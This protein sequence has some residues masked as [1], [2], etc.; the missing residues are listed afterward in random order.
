MSN[1]DLRKLKR[2]YFGHLMWRA[3]S[4]EKTLMLG[5]I[6]GRRRRGRQRMRWW[7]GITDSTDSSLSKLREMVMDREAC[8]C[9]VHEVEKSRTQLQQ[10]NN[11]SKNNWM[12]KGTAA[13][14]SVLELTKPKENLQSSFSFS[15]TVSMCSCDQPSDEL[16]CHSL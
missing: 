8:C 4:S 9:A 7:D 13:T 2:R 3:D 12:F 10:L 15:E 11:D 16:S 6:E 5:K 1:F 14:N